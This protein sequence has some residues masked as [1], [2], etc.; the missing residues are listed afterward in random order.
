MGKRLGKN[1]HYE[2]SS[3]KSG[4]ARKK[5]MTDHCLCVGNGNQASEHEETAH[6]MINHAKKTHARGNDI[7]EALRASTNLDFDCWEP[8]LTLSTSA[9]PVIGRKVNRKNGAKHEMDHIPLA[10]RKEP[11]EHNFCEA[12]T[13]L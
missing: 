10:R 5:V 13:E 11:C 4:H 8:T 2:A 9:D 3:A 1:Q 7:A 6:L 12:R